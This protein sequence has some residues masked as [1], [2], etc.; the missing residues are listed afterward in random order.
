MFVCYLSLSI[1]LSAL[2]MLV[3]KCNRW[4]QT[5]YTTLERSG[6]LELLEEVPVLHKAKA[7]FTIHISP[8]I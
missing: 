8:I 7:F 4:T 6:A 2:V 1:K 3:T 5:Q